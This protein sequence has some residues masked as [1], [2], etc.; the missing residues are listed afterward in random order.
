[1]TDRV[2]QLARNTCWGDAL[3][4][5]DLRVS[6]KFAIREGTAFALAVDTVNAFNRANVD[7]LNSVYGYADFVGQCPTTT[8]RR[9]KPG[10]SGVSDAPS[11]ADAEAGAVFRKAD[12]LSVV[13]LATVTRWAEKS[14][15]S[16]IYLLPVFPQQT[17]E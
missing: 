15:C 3:Y 2:G 6:R 14:G 16:T 12:F 11:L 1:V 5:A 4:S 10:G 9:R 13:C 7:E 17:M 8:E